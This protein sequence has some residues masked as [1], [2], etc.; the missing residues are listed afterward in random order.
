MAA[1]VRVAA[2]PVQIYNTITSLN[3]IRFVF[4]FLVCFFFIETIQAQLRPEWNTVFQKID[5]EVQQSSAAYS[6]LK[7]STQTIGHR[8]TGS[9][10]GSRAEKNAYEL[11]RSYGLD[12]RY[13]PFEAE[14]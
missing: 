10:Q 6:N 2:L 14:S 8:L 3:M 4:S 1:I 9:V 12:V 13:A 5:N 7:T 11:F